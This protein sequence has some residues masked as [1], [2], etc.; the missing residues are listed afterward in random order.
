M[1]PTPDLRA[2]L[3]LPRLRAAHHRVL[4]V[5]VTPESLLP[6]LPGAVIFKPLQGPV[7]CLRVFALQ[8]LICSAQLW[9]NQG[10]R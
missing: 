6:R 8:D 5:T 10:E 3:K 9:E 2:F 7:S 4:I 1:P